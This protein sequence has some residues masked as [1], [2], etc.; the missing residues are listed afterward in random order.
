MTAPEFPIL[1]TEPIAVELANTLYGAERLDFLR[2]THLVDQWFGQA[3]PRPRPVRHSADQAARVRELRDHV[4]VLL[5]AAVAGQVPDLAVVSAVNRF[6][7]ASPP[8]LTLGWAPDGTRRAGWAD[9]ATGFDATLAGLA[10][11]AIEV[12][13]ATTPARC[14]GPGCSMFFVPAHGRRRYCHPSC[15]H[16]DRQAR[17][18]R[19]HRTGATR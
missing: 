19:R 3:V 7:A 6:A 15:G 4:H 9:T 1:G 8:A 2:T 17:Y 18:Y 16:R 12:L 13:A 5:D 14:S 11:G 10:T